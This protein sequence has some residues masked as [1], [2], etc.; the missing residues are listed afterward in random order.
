MGGHLDIA[1]LVQAGPASG[2]VNGIVS[3]VWSD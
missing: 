3:A 2:A 1:R